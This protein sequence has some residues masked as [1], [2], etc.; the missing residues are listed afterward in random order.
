MS[1]TTHHNLSTLLLT[2]ASLGASLLMSCADALPGASGKNLGDTLSQI[3]DAKVQEFGPDGLPAF[4]TGEFGRLPG[5]RGSLLP[6]SAPTME[7][8]APLFQLDAA[9]LKLSSAKL[10]D[11]GYRH[12]RYRQ[13]IEGEEVIGSEL[14]VHADDKGTIYATQGNARRGAAVAP[15]SAAA[16][17]PADLGPA[18]AGGARSDEKLVYVQSS[19]DNTVYRAW[20]VVVEGSR[21]GMPY[22]DRVFTDVR[23]GSIVE[24]YPMVHTALNRRVHDGKQG[25]TLP[26]TLLRS[27]GQG[28]SADSTANF[29]YDALGSVHGCYQRLFG[30]DSYDNAGAT[31][32]STVHHRDNP[33]QPFVNAFWNGSQMVY[34]DGDGV[35]A[36]SL[37]L[38]FDV[39]AHEL[40]HAVTDRESGLIYAN[41]SGGINEALSDIFAAICEADLDGA[42]SPDTWKVG[43]DVWTPATAGDALR[44]MDN[45][46]RD[47]YSR[48]YYPERIPSVANPTPQN[49]QGGVHGNS[50]IANHAFYLLV[51]GG[52][53]VRGKTPAVTVPALGVTRAGQIWYRAATVYLTASSGF[54][55][56]RTALR[57]AA[58]D[59]FGAD[60]AAAADLSMDAVGVPGGAVPQPTTTALSNGQPL[61]GQ[62]AAAGTSK[63]YS[64]ELP[65]GATNIRVSTSGGSGDAD[66]YGKIGAAPN[67]SGDATFRSET[68]TSTESFTVPN[69]TSGKLFIQLLAF[70]AYS[71]VTIRA[72]YTLG[73]PSTNVLQNGVPV[74]NLGGAAGSRAVFRIDVPAGARNLS[75]RTT[76]GTGD[77]DLF[78]SFGVTPTTT[79]ADFRST[80]S[81]STETV[82]PAT[83]RAGTYFVLVS[84]FA[85][86]SGVT[87]T[88]TYTP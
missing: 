11:S 76:G 80:G 67:G 88:A 17:A 44:Y 29:N 49:D 26:G 18:Y 57:Q 33:A 77:A 25:V 36:S 24:V 46:T 87:L 43:E 64:I 20:S 56:L 2:G 72:E 34:G 86:Y 7:L 71:N 15:T 23:S 35:Q 60:A 8:I 82:T 51:A 50:G 83:T 22:K 55:S 14:I 10:D 47:N 1:R 19:R 59:L 62:S 54:Q 53:Q 5:G 70:S 6:V 52:K 63:I 84:G 66:L 12:F 38:S 68:G 69:G 48:D 74:T 13:T 3:P 45:P 39:T 30:R 40:T 79:S 37:A 16:A 27:E 21:D 58:T 85:T 41:E 9:D 42:V 65:P 75:F 4:V 73:G 61:S 31:L 78:V 81:S 32:I 28:P